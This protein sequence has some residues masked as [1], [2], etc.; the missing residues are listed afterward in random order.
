MVDPNKPSVIDGL[1]AKNNVLQEAANYR[2]IVDAQKQN[3]AMQYGAQQVI[4]KLPE[5]LA[6]NTVKQPTYSG[7]YGSAITP[8]QRAYLEA[9]KL[10]QFSDTTQ[11]ASAV[12]PEM[13]K[14]AKPG[15]NLVN[16]RSK[17]N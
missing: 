15:F 9:S 10:Q 17:G 14:N 7:L 6:A 1:A 11:P 16:D 2:A 8:E 13:L 12:T 5:I 3:S 4:N